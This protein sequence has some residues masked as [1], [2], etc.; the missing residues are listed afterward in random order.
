LGE[1]ST[2]F[3]HLIQAAAAAPLKSLAGDPVAETA[4][5]LPVVDL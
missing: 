3:D 1:P 2:L 4:A 5:D